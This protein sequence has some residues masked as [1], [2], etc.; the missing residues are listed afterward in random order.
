MI[1]AMEEAVQY[2]KI[3]NVAD[4][5]GLRFKKFKILARNV[6][7]FREPDG[8]FFATEISCKHQNWDL[9]TGTFDGDSVTCPRHGWKYNIRSGECLTHRSTP[10]RRYGLKVEDG[11]LYI[12][13]TPL[14]QQDEVRE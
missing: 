3:A 7:I 14:E 10:L 8:S 13:I 4:F 6:A 2:V 11:V 1:C 12:T 9:T 5:E